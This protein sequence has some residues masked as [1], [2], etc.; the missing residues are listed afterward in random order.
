MVGLGLSWASMMGNPYAMLAGSIPPERAGVY[1]GIFNGFIVLPM[2]L[3]SLTIPWLY[4]PVLGDNPENVI[5]L[6][7]VCLLIAAVL[8]LR[9]RHTPTAV[10]AVNA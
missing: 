1:M 9:V 3:E 2:L 8:V 10:P 5:R 7:G 4:H 6:G